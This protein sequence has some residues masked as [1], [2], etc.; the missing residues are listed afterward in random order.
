ML[1]SFQFCPAMV[2]LLFT[3]RSVCLWACLTAVT[4]TYAQ[5]QLPSGLPT[6]SVSGDTTVVLAG[7][8]PS[9]SHKT[10]DSPCIAAFIQP[11][12]TPTFVPQPGVGTTKANSLLI[13][14]AT[15]ISALGSV[16]FDG[17]FSPTETEGQLSQDFLSKL[18]EVSG[19]QVGDN[20]FTIIQTMVFEVG[21]EIPV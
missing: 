18:S 17:P 3:T 6:I 14:I 10:Y 1:S 19:A 11:M 7:R 16:L 9:L 2:G 13:G 21:S 4:L 15:N 8:S 12:L 5:S 20:V